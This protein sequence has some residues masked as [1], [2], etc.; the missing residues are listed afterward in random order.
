VFRPNLASSGSGSSN[1]LS[2]ISSSSNNNNNKNI[3]NENTHNSPTKQT[4]EAMRAA[5]GT[6]PQ[7]LPQPAAGMGGAH[8]IKDG[9]RWNPVQE[10]VGQ[11]AEGAIRTT[12][13]TSGIFE[14]K[15]QT[16]ARTNTNSYVW[17][18]RAEVRIEVRVRSCVRFVQKCAARRGHER[19]RVGGRGGVGERGCRVALRV[20]VICMR[21]APQRPEHVQMRTATYI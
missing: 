12:I 21:H 3:T 1:S 15:T 16:P 10:W 7:G 18:E 14:L 13:S 9:V 2:S 5:W 4:A 8:K 20:F 11:M 19:L 6:S 17:E